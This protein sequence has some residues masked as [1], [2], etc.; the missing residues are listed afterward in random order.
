MGVYIAVVI[1]IFYFVLA[2]FA[3]SILHLQGASLWILRGGLV[4][5]GLVAAGFFFWFHRR[6]QR[7]QAGIVSPSAAGPEEIGVLLKHADQKLRKS[8]QRSLRSFPVVF[9]IGEPNSAKTSTVLGAGL[10]PELLAGHVFRD[11]DVVSTSTI[12]V[13]L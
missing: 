2:W 5:I 10:E 4:L 1:L 6:L 11:S 9:V 12:N 8:K 13:W 7:R 3:G